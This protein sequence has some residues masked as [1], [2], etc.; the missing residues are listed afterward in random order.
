MSTASSQSRPNRRLNSLQS[1]D[2]LSRNLSRNSSRVRGKPVSYNDAYTFALRVAYLHRLLQPR[3]KKKQFVPAP[4]SS[5]RSTV[6]IGELVQD[7]SKA[8]NTKS[9]KFP[10]GF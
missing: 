4:K 9:S 6:M 3:P 7:F 1:S 10:H 5:R 2:R 8:S